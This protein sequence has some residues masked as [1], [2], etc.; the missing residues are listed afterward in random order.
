MDTNPFK[1]DFN[2]GNGMIEIRDNIAD[3]CVRFT[4]PL[5]EAR[6]LADQWLA[7]IRK[8]EAVLC[9]PLL[10][11]AVMDEAVKK[12]QAIPVGPDKHPGHVM[13]DFYTSALRLLADIEAGVRQALRGDSTALST[14][15]E[16]TEVMLKKHKHHIPESGLTRNPTNQP[17]G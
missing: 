3:G 4:C 5:D 8:A 14:C 6:P 9:S 2:I 1:A 11:A 7:A 12:I 16:I 13:L 17:G 10:N 15:M